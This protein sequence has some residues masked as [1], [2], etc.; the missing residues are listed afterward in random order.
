MLAD[1]DSLELPSYDLNRLDGL[2]AKEPR[3]LYL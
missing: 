1:D 2:D 3:I